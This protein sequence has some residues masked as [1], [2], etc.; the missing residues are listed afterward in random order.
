MKGKYLPGRYGPAGRPRPPLVV[1]LDWRAYRERFVELHGDPVMSGGMLLFEDGW[2]LDV[3]PGGVEMM[4]PEDAQELKRLRVEYWTHRLKVV[5]AE[6]D[7]LRRTVDDLRAMQ[8]GRGA[9]LQQAWIDVDQRSGKKFMARGNVDPD[10]IEC[11]RLADC[12]AEV[13]RCQDVLEEMLDALNR[14]LTINGQWYAFS[15][16]VVTPA[17][18]DS[19]H[20]SASYS[21]IGNR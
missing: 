13:V 20:V 17:D 10:A 8:A 18:R 14:G 1:T 7:L 4:P 2:R 9:P 15:S 6:R 19:W 21:M 11:G 3:R 16:A 12:E 5:A